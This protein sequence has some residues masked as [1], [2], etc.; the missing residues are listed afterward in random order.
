MPRDFG[1]LNLFANRTADRLPL[2]INVLVKGMARAITFYLIDGT[3]VDTG[4]ARSNWL[5]SLGVPLRGTIAPYTPYPKFSQANGRGRNETA[6]ANAARQRAMSA[7]A[8]RQPGQTLFIQNNVEYIGELNRGTSR[9]A[10]ALFVEASVLVGIST[11]NGL[12]LR[13]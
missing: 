3:P 13:I 7:I 9:Q 5:I 2:A 8:A 12:P 1:L 10:P 6:N 11:L 4:E